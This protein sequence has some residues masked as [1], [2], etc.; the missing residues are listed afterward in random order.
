MASPGAQQELHLLCDSVCDFDI[1]SPMGFVWVAQMW[2]VGLYDPERDR[3]PWR[4]WTC[5]RDQDSIRL[6]NK[7]QPGPC[8]HI[9]MQIPAHLIPR[10]NDALQ[11][12]IKPRIGERRADASIAIWSRVAK[13]GDDARI[14][15]RSIFLSPTLSQ[16]GRSARPRQ[17]VD[18]TF[19]WL[20]RVARSLAHV[21]S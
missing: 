11:C 10:S 18:I 21:F 13:H 2:P 8:I 14:L 3:R 15:G 17:L 12:H 7:G 16:N 1:F 9:C 6:I 20:R 4:E 19:L 5:C